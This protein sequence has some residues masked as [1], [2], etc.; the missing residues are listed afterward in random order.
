MDDM[1]NYTT[2]TKDG[3]TLKSST[4]FL[5][6]AN[7]NTFGALCINV[8]ISAF[9]AAERVLQSFTF[10]DHDQQIVET[11]SDD[12]QDILENLVA[13]AEREFGKPVGLMSKDERVTL[14][15]RL[16][17]KGAF[18]VKRAVTLIA[19]RMGVSRF[20]IYNYLKEAHLRSNGSD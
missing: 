17:K 8:D 6:D 16:E 3:K 10:R 7:N 5:T 14:I 18:R 12:M 2:H 4:M 13:E 1:F 19:D 20:T 9:L 15:A 11:F